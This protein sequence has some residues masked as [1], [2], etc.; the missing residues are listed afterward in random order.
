MYMS[1]DEGDTDMTQAQI[2]KAV[3]DATHAAFEA[4]VN[5]GIPMPDDQITAIY[6]L[7]DYLSQ[8]VEEVLSANEAE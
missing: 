4:L 7:S 8:F 2:D 5:A 3:E 6:S 1:T